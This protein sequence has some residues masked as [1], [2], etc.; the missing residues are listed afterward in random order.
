MQGIVPSAYSPACSCDPLRR[1]TI[2]TDRQ[3]VSP[4]NLLVWGE[5]LHAHQSRGI[6]ISNLYLPINFVL[7]VRPF[8]SSHA[9][10]NV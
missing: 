4:F 2:H 7:G 3:T 6:M 5:L 8:L 10:C 9:L 1:H